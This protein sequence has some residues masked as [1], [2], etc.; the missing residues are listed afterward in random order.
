[1]PAAVAD[2][3]G[4]LAACTAGV[5]L[6]A[7]RLPERLGMNRMASRARMRAMTKEHRWT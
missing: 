6:R 2:G 4:F 1:M 7:H 3:S 5:G